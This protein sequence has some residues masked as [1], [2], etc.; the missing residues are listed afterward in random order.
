[1]DLVLDFHS[2]PNVTLSDSQN[3]T[4]DDRHQHV[5]EFELMGK[6]RRIKLRA[7]EFPP[8]NQIHTPGEG[9]KS[10]WRRNYLTDDIFERYR[11]FGQRVVGV[12]FQNA[13]FSGGRAVP[14]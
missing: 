1:M 10:K 13:T 12:T 2:S 8:W 4:R 3:K 9:A 7:T 14:R 11:E 6:V 5:F